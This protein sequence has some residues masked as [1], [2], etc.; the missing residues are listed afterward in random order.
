MQRLCGQDIVCVSVMDWDHPFASS[1]HHL[2][3]LLAARNRVLFVDNQRNPLTV[4]VG[5]HRPGGR[6]IARAWAGLGPNPRPGASGLW[7]YTPPPAV[8]MGKLRHPAL[9]EAAYGWNQARLGTGVRAACDALGMRRPLL[10][11]SFNV[12]S[13]E[14]VIGRLD[15]RLVVYHCTDAVGAMP[16]AS[17]FADAI[18]R[19]LIARSDLVFCSSPVLARERGAGHPDCRWVPNGAD[20]AL[21]EQAADPSLPPH[22]ALRGWGPGPVLGFAGHLEERVDFALVEALAEA[23]P[24]WRFV[25][26]GP[27]APARRGA[28]ERLARR[29][30][31][32]LVGLLPRAQLPALLRGCDALLIPFVHS[33]Q[34]RAI[35]PLK[36]N[37]YLAT[38][39]PVATTGFADLGEAAPVVHV[40]DGV[41]GFAAAVRAA[42]EDHGPAQVAARRAIARSGDWEQRVIQMEQALLA[43]LGRRAC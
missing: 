35:Y 42:L 20:V 28:A 12:L 1:R 38:G 37:E 24:G 16:G 19:R 32:R 5:L 30:N 39:K 3:R 26:A 15:E 14:G 22:P 25:L 7:V 33:P 21:F 23:E 11:I 36:L 27:V 40:G 18:E 2:M 17:P 13:S 4:A 41:R 8:P 6:R 10:W 29:P 31:V 9:F 43:H 34:T